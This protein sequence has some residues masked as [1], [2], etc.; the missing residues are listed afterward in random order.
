MLKRRGIEQGVFGAGA[1]NR[2]WWAC[3]FVEK[4]SSTE[5]KSKMREKG[6]E[7]DNT[8]GRGSPAKETRGGRGFRR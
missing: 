1:G 7:Q 5:G 6:S 2:S 8:T 3:T 4:L